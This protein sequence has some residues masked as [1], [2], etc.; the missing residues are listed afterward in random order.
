MSTGAIPFKA[1]MTA[2]APGRESSHAFLGHAKRIGLLTLASR[3]LGMARE[4][5][6]AGVF[7]SGVVWSAF[8]VAFTVPNLFRKL[9]GEGA[10]SAAFIPLYAQAMD[11]D[12]AEANRFAAASVNLLAVILAALT[13]AGEL[14]LGA[15]LLLHPRADQ[16]LTIKLTAVMLPYVVLVCGAAFLGGVLQVHRRFNLPAA[17]P[18]ILNV[19]HIVVIMAGAWMIGLRGSHGQIEMQKQTV[20]VYWLAGF[21]LLAGGLQIV[22]LLPSLKAVGFRFDPRAAIWTPAVRK[23]VKLSIPV[24]LSA[25]V[26]QLSVL[27]DKGITVF[28]SQGMDASGHLISRFTLFGH[29]IAYPMQIG[30]VAR[31]NWAQ[32][33]YQFPLGIFAIAIAT[34]I[35]PR[36]AADAMENGR[37]KFRAALHSGIFATLLEGLPASLGLILVRY[38]AI[39]LLWEHGNFTP[40]DTMWVAR[41]VVLYSAAIWAY[42]LQQILN[43]AY[44]AMHDTVTP[45]IWSIV[46][47]VVNTVVEIPLVFTSL[48][49]AGMAA[50]TLVSF[51][52]Q[53]VVMLILLDRTVGGLDLRR[54]GIGTMKMLAGCGAMAGACWLVEKT[55]LFPAGRGM[56][57]SAVQ[58][59]I[60]MAVGAG[61]YL[62]TCSAL[63]LNVR[64][65]LLHAGHGKMTR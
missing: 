55:P 20:L 1:Q 28:L 2:G 14:I 53:A 57:A 25:G 5:V 61:A 44:Y 49:E 48:G 35:F 19:V 47:I 23:M 59:V 65:H 24:A 29:N 36:L 21:V 30:A 16:A 54:I 41:S 6:A 40:N 64:E 58:L 63:G 9:L 51:A 3:V 11:A 60:L 62:G 46:T 18:S 32:F 43:R 17:S 38:P 31:L 56:I 52:I 42:S 34:A 8:T 22:M 4:S 27:I 39:R 15:L 45:L 7:G 13:I 26:L 37:E 50:G 12:P 33:L 10:L